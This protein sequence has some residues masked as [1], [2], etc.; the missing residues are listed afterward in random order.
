MCPWLPCPA[1]RGRCAASIDVS[2]LARYRRP[3]PGPLPSS[4][5]NA[6]SLGTPAVLS[7]VCL[8]R[9]Y[10]SMYLLTYLRSNLSIRLRIYLSSTYLSVCPCLAPCVCFSGEALT[11]PG[12]MASC[13]GVSRGLGDSS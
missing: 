3:V 5:H 6:L 7:L 11:Y 1:T 12:M 4:A 2:Q 13:P 10:A 9:I 8:S